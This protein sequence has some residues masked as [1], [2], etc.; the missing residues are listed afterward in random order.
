M[1]LDD[2][3]AGVDRLGLDTPPFIY[4]IE[5][6][7]VYLALARE[8]F[9]RITSGALTA[10]SSVITLTEVLTQPYRVGNTALAQ[11]YQNF[12]LRS[13]NFSLDLVTADIADQA[14]ALRARYG[15]RTPD[16]LQIATALAAGCAALLTNDARLQRVTELRV[17]VLDDLE[18]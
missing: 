15:L 8:V 12:L 3:F 14:T 16:A 10:H 11:R 18:L 1:K 7:P 5:R 2:A 17:L 4:L 9:R 6:N 13:R